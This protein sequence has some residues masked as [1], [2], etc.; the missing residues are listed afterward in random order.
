MHSFDPDG[1]VEA[2]LPYT[3]GP[4]RWPSEAGGISLTRSV[5]SAESMPSWMHEATRD[6]FAVWSAVEGATFVLSFRFCIYRGDAH[7]TSP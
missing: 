6:A 2:A 7:Y 5:R 4:A 3:L 1:L